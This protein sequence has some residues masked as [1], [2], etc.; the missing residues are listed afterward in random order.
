MPAGYRQE[1]G[2]ASPLICFPEFREMVAGIHF[3]PQA[4]AVIIR[5]VFDCSFQVFVV[6]HR[7][8]QDSMQHRSRGL[9]TNAIAD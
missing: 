3:T 6:M 8:P 7:V 4:V 9:R 5:V 2:P 1:N